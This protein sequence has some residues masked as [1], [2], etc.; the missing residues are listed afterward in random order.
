M[1]LKTV[2]HCRI[3]GTDPGFW[4]GGQRSF[5]PRGGPEPSKWGFSPWHCLKTAWFWKKSWEQGG[6]GPQGLHGSA[7]GMDILFKTDTW[8]YEIVQSNQ[9]RKDK[10]QTLCPFHQ[11]INSTWRDSCLQ[12]LKWLCQFLFQVVSWQVFLSNHMAK[13]TPA[14]PSIRNNPMPIPVCAIHVC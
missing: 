6:L 4:S 10:F 9:E 8:E 2:P 3:A 5:D 11:L 12:V 1:G 7:S 13:V 14:N